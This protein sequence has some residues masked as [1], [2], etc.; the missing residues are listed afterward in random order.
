MLQ[1]NA[2]K[3]NLENIILTPDEKKKRVYVQNVK[4]WIQLYQWDYF[5]TLTFKHPVFDEIK[6]SNTIKKFLDY[7]SAEAFGKRSK[8][9]VIAFSTIEN[10][11]YDKSLHAHM[12]IQDPT[13]NILTGERR[14]S[15]NLRNAIITSWMKASPSAGNPALTGSDR[16][17]MKK[18]LDIEECIG[19]MLKQVDLNLNSFI[20]WDQLSLTGKKLLE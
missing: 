3:V 9:R 19:Y 7:L 6:V 4:K 14:D 10:G 11:T 8:K 12:L 1:S 2:N 13:H 20:P 17:W 16:E 18:V 15:F 5:L